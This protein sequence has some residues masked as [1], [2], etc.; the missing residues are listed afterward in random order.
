VS[1]SKHNQ[2]NIFNHY[3]QKAPQSYHKE[4]RHPT[5]SLHYHRAD[6]RIS[7]GFH[8]YVY[9]S[10]FLW[11]K[12]SRSC[13]SI[14]IFLPPLNLTTGISPAQILVRRLHTV[15]PKYSDAVFN[16]KSLG[17][18]VVLGFGDILNI[19]ELLPIFLLPVLV[20]ISRLQSPILSKIVR[21]LIPLDTLCSP[22]V[23]QDRFHNNI[24]H[25]CFLKK[26]MEFSCCHSIPI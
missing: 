23:L 26:D 3:Q 12:T 16:V 9:V 19:D 5:P 8:L 4:F 21:L 10:L 20:S 25:K 7:S 1:F 24:P 11:M 15:S 18:C 2:C 13:R 14:N 22:L 6:I 17:V